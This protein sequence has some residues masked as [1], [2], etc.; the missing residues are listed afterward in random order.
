MTPYAPKL[1][2]VRF[3][4]V[5]EWVLLALVLVAVAFILIIV[6]SVRDNRLPGVPA[7]PARF[8]H[9]PCWSSYYPDSPGFVLG[10]NS[11]PGSPTTSYDCPR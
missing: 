4:H 1:G 8:A 10:V 9:D 6:D 5:G 11:V 2:E 7:R 3:R